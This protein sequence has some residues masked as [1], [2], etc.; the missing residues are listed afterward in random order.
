MTSCTCSRETRR[1]HRADSRPS[2]T[3]TARG[4]SSD[5]VGFRPLDRKQANLFFRLVSARYQQG[6]IILT[7]D[8]H[9]RD[10]PEISAGD[11]ILT[12]AILDRL[13]H[14]VHIIHIDDRSYRLHEIDSPAQAAQTHSQQRR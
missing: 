1:S 14:R 7:S 13:L 3:S 11:E 2:A 4:S 12:T 8:K 9:V 5:E 6:S 10:W